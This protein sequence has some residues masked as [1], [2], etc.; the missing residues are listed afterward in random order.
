MVICFIVLI[1]YFYSKFV[2]VIMPVSLSQRFKL[3]FY[4]SVQLRR[5]RRKIWWMCVRNSFAKDKS[6]KKL[7]YHVFS[8][9]SV[10]I[11]KLEG[12]DLILQHNKVKNLRIVSEILNGLVIK[13]GER[14]SLYRLVGKPTKKRG[15]VN[16]L[17]LSRGK[18]KGEIGGGLCQIANLLHWMVLHTD[19]DITER[20]HHSV[21]IFPDSDRKV[22]FG[23]GATLFYNFKDF[24]FQNN[25]KSKYQILMHVDE[26]YLHGQILTDNCNHEKYRVFEMKHSFFESGGEYYRYNEIWREDLEKGEKIMLFANRYKTLYKPSVEAL[27][28]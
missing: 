21:D 16:G 19:L 11:R 10:L 9:S 20:H 26:E 17:E 25:T 15:F 5:A 18:M 12:V 2:I 8:H 6:E 22:P 24:M 23:T 28:T 3:A 14:F 13:P 7:P 27:S 1:D 4:I